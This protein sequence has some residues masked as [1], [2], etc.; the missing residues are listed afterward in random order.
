MTEEVF[1][2]RGRW[3][4]WFRGTAR[5]A[6]P[7]SPTPSRCASQVQHL[8]Q[9]SVQALG[10]SDLSSWTGWGRTHEAPTSPLWLA[11][12]GGRGRGS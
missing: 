7:N 8:L 6:P 11:G 4:S 3:P 5:G 9:P 1:T 2:G 12:A 10:D